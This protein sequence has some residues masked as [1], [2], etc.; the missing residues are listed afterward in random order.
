[1]SKFFTKQ[2]EAFSSGIEHLKPVLLHKAYIH[3]NPVDTPFKGPYEENVTPEKTISA[4]VKATPI[5]CR[6]VQ[7]EL[8]L[9]SL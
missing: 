8:Y 6:F 2:T 7:V 4:K 1:M 3:E 9:D 5:K